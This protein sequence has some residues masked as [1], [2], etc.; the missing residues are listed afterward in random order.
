VRGTTRARLHAGVR[1]PLDRRV[2]HRTQPRPGP[3]AGRPA[4]GCASPTGGHPHAPSTLRPAAPP[5]GEHA[6]HTMPWFH[7]LPGAAHARL[8]VG[9]HA[10]ARGAARTSGSYTSAASF[11]CSLPSASRRSGKRSASV[12]N[13]PQNTIGCTSAYPPS[14]SAAG[15]RLRRRRRRVTPRP[16][17]PGCQAA[18]PGSGDGHGTAQLWRRCPC[19][20]A[21]CGHGSPVRARRPGYTTPAPGACFS[22]IVS[23]TRAS[24]TA[25]MLAAR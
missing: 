17:P 12:G 18:L 24:A 1:V 15:A 25:L 10:W 23:P 2:C 7:A 9:R 22:V 20:H 4:T 14:A 6:A 21:W 8:W 19:R 3:S 16:H 11:S 5:R 13:R